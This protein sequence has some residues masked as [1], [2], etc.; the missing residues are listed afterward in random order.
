MNKISI[1]GTGRVGESTAQFIV[2][3]QLCRH[4]VL[5]DVQEG[6]P[7]GIALDLWEAAPLLKFD[8]QVMGH[9]DFSELVDSNLVIITAGFARKPGMARSDVLVA[10]IKIIDTILDHILRYCPQ[11]MILMVSNPVDVLTYYAWKKTAWDR[12]RIFGQAGVLDSTRMASFVALETGFSTKDISTLVIG[13]HSEASMIPLSRYC[14]IHGIPIRHFLDQEQIQSIEERTRQG[15]AE[16][17]SLRKTS[18][19]YDAPAAAIATMVDA[20]IYNRRRILPSVGIFQGEYGETEIALGMPCVLSEKGM[21]SMVELELT[22][23][24][25]RLFKKAVSLVKQDLAK[26]PVD[27]KR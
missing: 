18:S 20:I 22:S 13:G 3:K 11:T 9:T 21:E 16:V 1:I 15:G 26:L 2:D 4:L 6:L 5:L 25:M 10:N 8:T 17:L 12:S 27:M 24:E 19:A 23:D 14:T 7:E